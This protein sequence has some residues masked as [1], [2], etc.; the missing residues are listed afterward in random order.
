MSL[1]LQ[2]RA[3]YAHIGGCALLTTTPFAPSQSN[4]PA[5]G[6]DC[7][8]CT[9]GRAATSFAGEKVRL[10]FPVF[11]EGIRAFFL[12]RTKIPKVFHKGSQ[13]KRLT[14]NFHKLRAPSIFQ[15]LYN[16]HHFNREGHIPF[17]TISICTFLGQVTYSHVSKLEVLE[18][19]P[20]HRTRLFGRGRTTIGLRRRNP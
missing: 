10:K 12:T 15:H 19:Q 9:R 4:F 8:G 16:L 1:R 17:P 5:G 13:T 7:G 11:L 2:Q 14:P 3:A 18:N 6:K 20:E